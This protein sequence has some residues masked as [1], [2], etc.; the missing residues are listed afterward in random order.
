MLNVA[1]VSSLWTTI[2]HLQTNSISS[3]CFAYKVWKCNGF[4]EIAFKGNT[5]GGRAADEI[6]PA[7]YYL[8]LTARWFA[9][10]VLAS[11][12]KA[13]S[14]S[15]EQN[16]LTFHHR[17]WENTDGGLGHTSYLIILEKD[18][19]LNSPLNYL[20]SNWNQIF[21]NAVT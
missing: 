13:T 3:P 19:F 17:I 4:R 5:W 16:I 6:K 9:T 15:G 11:S 2:S 8:S 12:C 18:C 1:S 7:W 10:V 20:R 14:G 21:F